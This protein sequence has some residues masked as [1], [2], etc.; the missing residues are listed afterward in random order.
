[1]L[2][3]LIGEQ[4][5]IFIFPF[6]FTP[7]GEICREQE[8]IAEFEMLCPNNT[9]YMGLYLRK[10][11]GFRRSK[12]PMSPS[13]SWPCWPCLTWSH[14]NFIVMHGSKHHHQSQGSDLSVIW[15]IYWCMYFLIPN[16][17]S[18]KETLIQYLEYPSIILLYRPNL[19][20]WWAQNWQVTRQVNIIIYNFCV[21]LETLLCYHGNIAK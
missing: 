17:R 21:S 10:P 9:Y 12:T 15:N 5:G 18:L 20:S 3:A 1:M 8:G 13:W 6:S 14:F 2:T 7:M 16:S 19:S 4:P 11:C